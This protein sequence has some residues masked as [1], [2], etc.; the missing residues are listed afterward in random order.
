MNKTVLSTILKLPL[1]LLVVLAFFASIY[2]A[3]KKISGINYAT[4]LILGIILILYIV[5]IVLE[6]KKHNVHF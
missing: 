2:A 3:Y 1:I 6:R 5:G 4:P